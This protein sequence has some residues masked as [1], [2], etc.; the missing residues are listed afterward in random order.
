MTILI[1]LIRLLILVSTYVFAIEPL[2]RPKIIIGI[3]IKKF[4]LIFVSKKNKQKTR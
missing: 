3:I 4:I 2:R 1:R